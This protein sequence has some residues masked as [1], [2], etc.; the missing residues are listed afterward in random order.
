MAHRFDGRH[1]R[2]DVFTDAGPGRQDFLYAVAVNVS[3]T[4]ASHLNDVLRGQGWRCER[5]VASELTMLGDK[6][7]GQVQTA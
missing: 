2:W 7:D 5:R 4:V 6:L 3:Y 1:P